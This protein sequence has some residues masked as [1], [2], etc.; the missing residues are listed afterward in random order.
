[1]GNIDQLQNAL[2]NLS[3]NAF[4]AMPDSGT[5]T[6]E[7]AEFSPHRSTAEP[8][9]LQITI[10][11]TGVGMSEEIKQ[12]IFEPFFATKEPGKGTGLGLSSVYGCIQ[13]HQGTI[14]VESTVNQ[15]TV[16]T[17]LLPMLS[18]EPAKGKDLQEATAQK[19][20]YCQTIY[21]GEQDPILASLAKRFL[22]DI[23]LTVKTF[24]SSEKLLNHIRQNPEENIDLFLL[25]LQWPDIDSIE[26]F[27]ELKK[28]YASPRAV[29]DHQQ[30]DQ[31]IILKRCGDGV[32]GLLP[33]GFT[34]E[35]FYDIIARALKKVELL[36]K[37]GGRQ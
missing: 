17:I 1:M 5:L 9:F 33:K 12:H 30:Y 21:I 3:I 8:F 34:K 23:G 6:F 4:D 26:T 10:A 37:P 27:S 29:F 14:T 32:A 22:T 18:E 15:G 20:V 28:V 19:Q 24:D 36:N 25:N 35:I 16:F 11:D 13:N 31:E 7:T 2:I